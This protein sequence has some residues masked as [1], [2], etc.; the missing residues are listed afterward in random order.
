MFGK[1]KQAPQIDKEQLELIENAQ[2]RVKQKKRLYAHFVLFLIGCVFLIVANTVLGIGKDFTIA[3][4]NWFVYA[5]LI[6]LFLFLY[7]LFN[8]FVTH[9]FMGKAWEQQQ[10]EKLV[11]KQQERID[12]MKEGFRK[13]EE[14]KAK[15]EVYNET[16]ATTEKTTPKKKT[17]ELTIIA[18][19]AENDAIG[20][21]NQLIWDL[22]NDLKRFKSLTSGHHIIMGRK[23]FE[24]FPKPL[25]NR[26][27]VV[28]TRQ[29]DYK[30]PSGVIIVHS[31]E[32]AI[33]ASRNDSQPF[34]I[35]G[36]QIYEQSMGIADKIELTRVHETFEA[37]AFFPKI[38]TSVWKETENV[39]HQKDAEH[40][41]DF[42]FITYERI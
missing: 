37:D 9:K 40:D 29:K 41:H 2:R 39:F 3:G 18:A 17:S 31:L 21:G 32:D 15:S 1:K 26:T 20:R 12:K 38:D 5:I 34:I 33:D 24:S 27:H 22:S 7:H 11:A 23:T 14:I 28:I 10:M 6:W 16:L 36:G 8:V 35:G 19:A 13:E 30:A 4:I 42:S 25:P